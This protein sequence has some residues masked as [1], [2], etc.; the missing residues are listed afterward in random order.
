MNEFAVLEFKAGNDKEYK[1][2][3]ILDSTIYAKKADGHLPKLYY[4][5][6]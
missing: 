6:A 5:I 2:E 4:L 1:V 3:A